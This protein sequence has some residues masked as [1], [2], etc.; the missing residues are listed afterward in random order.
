MVSQVIVNENKLSE[1]ERPDCHYFLANATARSPY[2][3]ATCGTD[4]TAFHEA[5]LSW[6]GKKEHLKLVERLRVTIFIVLERHQDICFVGKAG[7][8]RPLAAPPS[9]RP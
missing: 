1:P 6:T 9:Y 4:V 3:I 8:C 7:D 5:W 2:P